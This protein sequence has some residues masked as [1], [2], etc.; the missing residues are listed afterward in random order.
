MKPPS[1]EES[2]KYF[3]NNEETFELAFFA[4]FPLLS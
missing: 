3:N 2:E 1:K 4:L